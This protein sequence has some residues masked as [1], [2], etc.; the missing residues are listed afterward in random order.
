MDEVASVQFEVEDGDINSKTST[1]KSTKLPPSDLRKGVAS[2]VS[3]FC[4]T[5]Y[6]ISSVWFTNLGL[7]IMTSK[8]SLELH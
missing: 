7:S 1:D 5:A 2:S 4:S 8:F 3:S 6:Y